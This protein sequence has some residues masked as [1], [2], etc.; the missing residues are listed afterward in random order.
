[1]YGVFK[2]IEVE[3]KGEPNGDGMIMTFTLHDKTKIHAIA[4]PQGWP[5]PTGPTWVYLF[6]NEGLTLIDTGAKNSSSYFRGAV[7][8]IGFQL[9]D[10]ER[11][12]I[13]HGHSDHDGSLKE[14]MATTDIKLFAHHLYAQPLQYDPWKIKPGRISTIHSIMRDIIAEY[15]SA[16]TG[17]VTPTVSTLT[18]EFSKY[19]QYRNSLRVD[20]SLKD[21]ESYGA[22]TFYHTPG[23]TPEEI[24][25]LFSNV[26][27]TGDHILPEITPHPTTKA[28]FPKS[29]R[30][31][32][33]VNR[34]NET[35]IYGLR[36]YLNSLMRI[37]DVCDNNVVMLPAH[38]LYNRGKLNIQAVSVRSKEIANHH[39]SRLN[40]IIQ[41][42]QTQSNTLEKITTQL[43]S[44]RKLVGVNYYMALSEAVSHIELLEDCGDITINS[45]NTI[46]WSGSKNYRQIINDLTI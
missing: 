40:D 41:H 9:Q 4:I 23:H 26:M 1:M 10:I 13:T 15:D 7:N 6:E 39:I 33:H 42:I 28:H 36:P 34:Y 35:D 46:C 17:Q 37:R 30:G 3:R 2:N 44:K 14:L 18:T 25:I 27:F 20:Q 24:C 16:N 31:C 38:R 32:S 12:V 45:N 8:S 29:L 21:G 22:A 11:I 19:I 43:F 5:S